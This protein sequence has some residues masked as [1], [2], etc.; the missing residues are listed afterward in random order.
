[1]SDV[2]CLLV[3]PATCAV[4]DFK[5]GT[6]QCV[7]KKWRCDGDG[8]CRDK[9][10]E[11]ACGTMTTK[12]PVT[13]P[14]EFWRCGNAHCIMSSWKCDGDQDCTDGSDESNCGMLFMA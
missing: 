14:P 8:D 11:V 5:C 12:A 10:D 13:C 1:M 7:P 9:S 4:T 3:A 6:G 2:F